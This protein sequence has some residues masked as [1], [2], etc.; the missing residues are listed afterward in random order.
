MKEKLIEGEKSI[1]KSISKSNI[2]TSNKFAK[3]AK[4]MIDGMATMYNLKPRSTY[5][6]RLIDLLKCYHATRTQRSTNP[7]PDVNVL[8]L[9]Q[10]C[11]KLMV[12]NAF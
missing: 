8:G 1:F 3:I 10:K 9:Q 4:W 12:E 6:E 11:R 7:G 2:K 5:M